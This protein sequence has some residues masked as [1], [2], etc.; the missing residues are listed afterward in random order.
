MEK[1]RSTLDRNTH[2]NGRPTGGEP[3]ES[4]LRQLFRSPD[5]RRVLPWLGVSSLLSNVLALAL[6]LA[7]L[8]ILDRVVSNQ[9]LET[10]AFL[11][12]GVVVALFLEEILRAVNGRVTSWLGARFE[13]N[14]SVAALE[15]LM[16]VPLQRY[17]KEEPG[18]HEERILA[19]TKVAEFYS[20]QALL[21]LFDLPFVALYPLLIYIIGGWLFLVPVAL[22]LLF[23]YLIYYFGN[24][25]RDQV[26]KRNIQDDRRLGFLTEVLA[27][28]YSV[29]TLTMESLMLRRYER[30]QETNSGLGEALIRG[31]ALASNIGT[32]FSQVM[33]VAVVF[34]SSWI[35]ISGKMTPG[36]LA[37]CMMLSV[38]ALQPLRRG[39]SVW[40]R[41]QSFIAAQDR[42]NQV[43]AMPYEHDEG[44]PLMPPV[45]KALELRNITLKFK[46]ADSMAVKSLG[47]SALY[48]G[49][50]QNNNER[51]ELFS[52]LSFN[53]EAGQ[54]VAILGA[55]GSG[56]TSL[57]SLMN[58]LIT[59]DS[60]QVLVD[61]EPLD[62]FATRSLHKEIA[63]LPQ[64][65][66]IVSGNI[67]ENMTMFD[68]SLNEEALGLASKLGLDKIVAGM[69]LGYET[70]V[71]NGVA[72]TL[73]AGLRQIIT[74]IRALVRKPSVILFDEANIALDMR[75]DN[76]LRDY[77]AEQ[78]GKCSVVLV[79]HRP[80]LINLA[81]KTYSLLDGRLHEGVIETRSDIAVAASTS[82]DVT[83]LS[84]RPESVVDLA[85][86]IRRQ[87]DEESD[88]SVS[89]LPLLHAVGWEGQP[90][91]L[92][93]AM[94]HLVK[95]MDIT[96]L[97]SVMANLEFFPKHLNGHLARLDSR[98]MPCLFAPFGKPA[99]I[100][101]ERLPNGNVK[102][103][104]SNLR[105]ETEIQP[106]ADMGEIYLFQKAEVVAK[107]RRQE[108]SWI[109][110]LLLR[111]RNHIFLAFILTI[112]GALLAMAAP[113]FVR[114]IYDL[115]LPSGDIVMGA[116][117]MIGVVIAITADGLLRNLKSQIMAFVGGRFE[118]ILGNTLFNRIINLPTSSTDGAT[119]SNQVGR[120]KNLESLRDFFLG[121]A[122]LLVFELPSTL[123]LLVAIAVINPWVLLVILAS[124]LS[125]ALLWLL[126]RKS[127]EISVAKSG[128]LASARWEF[129]NEAL[130]DMHSIRAVG[131]DQSWV[132]RFRELSGKSVMA[133]FKN[134][135]LHARVNSMAQILGSATG[136]MALALSAYL[137]IQGTIS[138]GTM[139]ATMM[140]LWR[141]TGPIQNIF[142]AAT[143]VV[144]IRSGIRQVENLMRIRGESDTG[145]VQT[146]SPGSGGSLSFARVSFR[147]ANDADPVLLGVSFSVTPRQVIAIVGGNGSGK[148]TLLKLLER[149][150]VPQAGTI[151]INN[152]DIRQLTA[153]DLRAKISY[154]PQECELYYGTVA[155]NLRLINPTASDAEMNWAV[156]MAGLAED[157]AALP[158]GFNTRISSSRS[159][160]QPHGFRQR[161]S[162]ARAMLKPA[163]IVLLDEPGT[164][165]DRSGDEA[166]ERCIAWLRGRST[167]IMV[168]HRPAHMRAA[169]S[170]ILMH[171]GSVVAMD[172]FEK[173][174][175]KIMSE[176]T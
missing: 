43:F 167:V 168:T 171:R 145:V 85:A 147:Y 141:V 153:D 52:N 78:K 8:Q 23:S 109:G 90:R 69:K 89:L 39:L 133:N 63:M 149:I 48:G 49:A 113:L 4:A 154:M 172:S 114:A 76:L 47:K 126:T 158:Q 3:G 148:S 94:P 10:L 21:V 140:I 152:V 155:Q 123:V 104:D 96:V 122:S 134:N 5:L 25:M 44:K 111:F 51:G 40:M 130:T 160:Q 93:D 35:V 166:L 58:G 136:L 72:D 56:K 16:H 115:V 103:F 162:L 33:I 101:L 41:Y 82:T 84:A 27:G 100:V 143:S 17:Q 66:T 169:D 74:I 157:I 146:I 173:I 83:N 26:Q 88:L 42:L 2:G 144:H 6:P 91:E 132:S 80:S 159:S 19:T 117:L 138:G 110:A 137:T 92:A 176:L 38:R 68:A 174:K 119:V 31:N 175:D 11:V 112:A 46:G 14:T 22:L 127:S 79:T 53:L 37:A 118:Y 170:V 15:R 165:M 116:F 50:P 97:C 71:G 131:A 18:I 107:S 77:L 57:L 13:H 142:L 128:L 24:W 150:Y 139:M 81:D 12:I 7:I 129:L 163:D 60:G 135:Q 28:I 73:P 125:F 32:L 151:R 34:A 99:M 64:T 55:S 164:G 95:R 105:A 102:I 30:L 120:F 86:V 161:F 65:G 36:G 45:T 124:V 156:G 54:F 121:P 75:L 62:R 70:N 87:F 106:T 1:A 20:G 108:T 67:L 29:K 9:S 98:L 59:P 61:G